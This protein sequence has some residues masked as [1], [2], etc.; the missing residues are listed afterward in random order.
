MKAVTCELCG[1]NDIIKIEGYFVCQHCGTKYSIDEAK[2]YL[3]EDASFIQEDI[4]FL[5]DGKKPK[6][7]TFLFDTG[8]DNDENAPHSQG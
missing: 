7:E 8:K 1:S 3:D 4:D 5:F 6:P 2:H